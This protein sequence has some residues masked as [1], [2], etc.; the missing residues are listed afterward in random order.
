MSYSNREKGSIKPRGMY[1]GGRVHV[2]SGEATTK[3][4][5]WARCRGCR[6]ARKRER[7]GESDKGSHHSKI[8]SLIVMKG[9]TSPKKRERKGLQPLQTRKGDQA[10]GGTG[11]VAI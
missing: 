9:L 2:D 8:Y 6:C 11:F 1:R 10:V 5:C 3:L 7:Q 4:E